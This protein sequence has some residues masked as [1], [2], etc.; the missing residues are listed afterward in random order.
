APRDDEQGG[1]L[2]AAGTAVGTV[3]VLT[4][5]YQGQEPGGGASWPRPFTARPHDR[6]PPHHCRPAPRRLS[7]QRGGGTRR[8]EAGRPEEGGLLVRG[9][10]RAARPAPP[11]LGRTRP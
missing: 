3:S 6:C 1:R 4:E 8:P 10:P 9:L 7:R 5:P 11:L 2:P